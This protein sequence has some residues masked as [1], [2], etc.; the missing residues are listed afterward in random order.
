VRVRRSPHRQPQ[1]EEYAR[2]DSDGHLATTNTA[3]GLVANLQRQINGTHHHTSKKHP[4]RYLEEFDYKY[5]TRGASD[6]ERTE[7]AI[8]NIEGKR[9][10]LYKPAG[11]R[12]AS[13]FDRKAGEPRPEREEEDEP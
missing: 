5:N 8:G 11:G 10:N 13:L 7:T 4:P 1:R 3:E 2:L 6:T 9:L 12:G